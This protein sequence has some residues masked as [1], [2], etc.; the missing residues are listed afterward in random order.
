MSREGFRCFAAGDFDGLAEL[1]AEDAVVRAPEGWPES[2]PFVGRG[3]VMRQFHRLW[4][5]WTD[6]RVVVETDE[7]HGDWVVSRV[8]W[9]ACGSGS[10][11]PVSVR[12]SAATRFQA[13]QIAEVHYCWAHEE[14]LEAMR[15]VERGSSG[16]RVPQ[17]TG[18]PRSG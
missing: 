7:D 13:G 16:S 17:S 11:A 12:Y 2:G 15:R 4:E 6:H 3:A 5:G 10:G 14:A 18:N 1:F 9:E 8:R